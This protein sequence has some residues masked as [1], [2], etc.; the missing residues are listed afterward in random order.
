MPRLPPCA[1][2]SASMAQVNKRP[3]TMTL[4]FLFYVIFE[5]AAGES[6]IVFKS[7]SVLLTDPEIFEIPL[8]LQTADNRRDL[9]L[10]SK[11]KDF[12]TPTSDRFLFPEDS[13]NFEERSERRPYIIGSRGERHGAD[14]LE[15]LPSSMAG[16][17]MIIG[18]DRGAEGRYHLTS[19]GGNFRRRHHDRG[20]DNSIG[21][22]GYRRGVQLNPM[23]Y[24]PLGYRGMGVYGHGDPYLHSSRYFMSE[25]Y[26]PHMMHS[27]GMWG[28]G[29]YGPHMHVSEDSA[30]IVALTAPLPYLY[31][32]TSHVNT[33]A[34]LPLLFS[35]PCTPFVPQ[36]TSTFWHHF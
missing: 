31:S 30:Y 17:G 8:Q 29:H 21:L 10:K 34:D 32:S 12:L 33:F 7:D 27:P 16:E 1:Y 2:Y 9:R 22:G 23:M 19:Y 25:G 26:G 4:S 20:Y 36:S 35:T 28:G 13:K 14:R 3:L 5:L 6:R 24:G 15:R 18:Y 11:S